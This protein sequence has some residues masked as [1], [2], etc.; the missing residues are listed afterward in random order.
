MKKH[1][2]I[3]QINEG[4]ISCSAPSRLHHALKKVGVDTQI[5]T[6]RASYESASINVV[7][8]KFLYKVLRKI[9][10]ILCETEFS[11]KYK[12]KEGMPFSY[13]RVGMNLSKNPIIKNADI[14][15]LHWVCGNFLSMSG[16]KKIL[17]LKK[18]VIIICHDNWFFTGGCH[19]RLG[20]EK[21]K[22]HCA[23]CPQLTS[24]KEK[25]CSYRLFEQKK[26]VL[27]EGD[28]TVV[29]P[30]R[31]MDQNVASSSVLKN[32][33]HYVIPNALNTELFTSQNKFEIRK[34][35]GIKEND[36]VLTYGAVNAT[37]VPYKG[38]VQLL[39]ALELFK[40]Q[41]NDD[42]HIVILVFGS[43][44]EEVQTNSEFEIRYLGYLEEKEMVKLYSCTDVYI[45]PSL[46]DSFNY[47]VAESLACETPV[48]SFATGGIV[49]IIDHKENGYLAEYNNPTDLANGITW[50]LEN[51][52]DNCL[53]KA[54]RTKVVNNYSE[55]VVAKQFLKLYESIMENDNE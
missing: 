17:Q 53:G 48:V 33:P 10:Y 21:H 16:I 25:D 5:I 6:T 40:K 8:K 20:C 29:S 38:Y 28:I 41:Y 46:E 15:E 1:L 4:I 54:G 35:Y 26:K 14:I 30:S 39:S 2:N 32:K 49:D 27:K 24:K 42:K 18:P 43:K 22:T 55:E 47:T 34:E 11:K 3:V 13:Y 44:K 23:T 50:I 52:K 9:D 7:N 31:W 12:I 37:K 51:N 45:V 36:I 19:V